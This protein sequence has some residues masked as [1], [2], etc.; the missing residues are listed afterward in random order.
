[1][2][3]TFTPPKGGPFDAFVGEKI[4]ESPSGTLHE[5]RRLT[6]TATMPE[7]I[8]VKRAG[9]GT[10]KL[11][12]LERAVCEKLDHPSLAGF[13]GWGVTPNGTTA[14]AFERLAQ[15]PLTLLNAPAR[16]PRYRDPETA[17]YP[18]P[19]G[20]ALELGMDVLLA[21]EFL[22]SRGYVHGAIKHSTL[23]ARVPGPAHDP[24]SVLLNVAEGAFEGVLGGLGAARSVEF[25]EKL[26][27]GGA[28]A[29][30]AP[31]FDPV[32]SPPECIAPLDG[33]PARGP[34]MDVY[35]FGLLFYT[36]LTGRLPYDHLSPPPEGPGAV[37]IL[38]GREAQGEVFPFSDAAI[39]AL[40]LHDVAFEGIASRAW[41]SCRSALA[42]LFRVTLDPN[43]AKRLTSHEARDYFEREL[44]L[45]TSLASGPRP[46]TARLI[47][48]RT[49]V[50][51]L[52]G[53]GP[54]GGISIRE[55]D[56][57]IVVEEK[58]P[59][60][61]P[62]LPAAEGIGE[63]SLVH[64]KAQDLASQTSVGEGKR[65]LFPEAP[66][67][68]NFLGEVLREFQAKRPL[69]VKCP[70]LVTKTT[71]APKDLV[72]SMLF[73]LGR[74]PARMRVDA[75]GRAMETVR[76][77][78]G[79]GGE[80]C[81]IVVAD[82]SVSKKHLAVERRDGYWWVEDL[83]STNGT[84]VDGYEVAKNGRLRVRGRF[85]TIEAGDAKLTFMEEPELIVFLENALS[86]WREAF[87]KGRK[88]PESVGRPTPQPTPQPT[89]APG[90][91]DPPTVKYPREFAKIDK[92]TS[93]AITVPTVI[94]KDLDERLAWHA[95]S[96][97]SF[98]MI[99]RGSRVEEP[100][101][102]AEALEVVKKNAE[103]LLSIEVMEKDG[104][105]IVLFRRPSPDD[106]E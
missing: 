35:G 11:L 51:R 89:P 13:L 91:V 32:M 37:I 41:S 77:V 31:A 10:G 30:L 70:V 39:D 40:P 7:Q 26:G 58:R 21:L 57:A 38:K 80:G 25:L 55:E 42:H 18:L 87:G 90:A 44:G 14:L 93:L 102:L 22:H 54:G 106:A 3:V 24:Q 68:M 101:D 52:V 103:D 27:R 82:T 79:R 50:N 105:N 43:P 99:L 64:F 92:K 97:A 34:A 96:Q 4:L 23:F 66:R 12:D 95:K 48:M 73:S 71:F 76:V 85:A 84:A 2:K 100:E 98:R 19:L 28:D 59:T 20:R 1:M 47:Q 75:S 60:P 15:N 46:W 56:G 81:D 29:A 94:P 8:V 36:L 33:I 6:G 74:S 86:A 63:G 72:Q 69:P 9:Q 62:A 16:R 104:G 78:V 83:G 45:R 61:P 17:Y 88:S 65:G 49:R 5:A 53:D 67:G